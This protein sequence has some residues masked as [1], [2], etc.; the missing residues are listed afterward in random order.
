[1]MIYCNDGEEI[2]GDNMMSSK[3]QE[4]YFMGRFLMNFCSAVS[5]ANA[6]ILIKTVV[7]DSLYFFVKAV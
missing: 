2:K 4:F 7:Q 6:V 3:K 1:M 5:I